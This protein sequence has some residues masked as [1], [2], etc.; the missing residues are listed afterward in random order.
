MTV[1]IPRFR[2]SWVFGER[3]SF[4]RH[5]VYK[6]AK[7]RHCR[8]KGYWKNSEI[9]VHR[10]R[11]VCTR[12]RVDNGLIPSELH[13]IFWNDAFHEAPAVHHTSGPS[14]I[15]L[16]RT[17]PPAGSYERLQATRN[18]RQ[19]A[20]TAVRPS[21]MITLISLQEVTQFHRKFTFSKYL[22]FKRI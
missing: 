14:L 9:K 20:D 4:Y 18:I 1:E 21:E 16:H 22:T 6:H 11:I 2:F 15:T 17:T 5:W 8:P 19:R 7:S 10:K 3:V 12:I 13:D